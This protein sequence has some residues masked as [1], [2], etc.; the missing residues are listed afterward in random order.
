[1]NWSATI[2][3]AAIGTDGKP[4]VKFK[5][6]DD[7]GNPISGLAYPS[8]NTINSTAPI[9]AYAHLGF[10][11][12][13]LV[14]GTN[15]S[16]NRWVSYVV[17][18]TPS[19]KSATD[20]TTGTNAAAQRVPTT[21]NQGTMV[22]DAANPGN[23]TD[24]FVRSVKD[25][26]G[27]VDAG[28]YTGNNVKSF[29]D[30]TT[31]DPTLTHRVALQLQGSM[32]GTGTNMPDGI[33]VTAAVNSTNPVAAY[34]DFRPDGGAV[35]ETRTITRVEVCQSCHKGNLLHGRK[36]PNLCVTCHTQ[37]AGYGYA[38]VAL[39]A[40]D[41]PVGTGPNGTVAESATVIDGV[42]TV[43][44]PRWIHRIHMGE[45]LSKKNQNIRGVTPNEIAFPQDQRNCV[46]CHDSSATAKYPTPDG[47]HWKT[48][49]SRLACGGCHDGIN[50]ATGAG[51]TLAG[52]NVGHWGKAQADDSKCSLCHAP[53]D[54]DGYH[55]P[56]SP[57]A[58]SIKALPAGSVATGYTNAAAIAAYD[59]LPVGAIKVG[60]DI[61]SVTVNSSGN[62]AM[63]FRLLQNGTAVPFNTYSATG[64]TEIWDN[65][66]GAPGVEIAFNVPQDGITAP[67]DYNA[68]YD[69]PL[70]GIWNGKGTGT[71][72]GTLT[73]PDASGWYTVTLTG[74]KI[75]T[76]ATM[77]TMGLG[78]T[79][80]PQATALPLTQT[81]LVGYPYAAATMIGGLIVEVPNAWM[82]AS[83]KTSRRLL[84]E[85][86]RC[87]TCHAKLG[88]FAESAYHAG[89]RNNSQSCN[90]CHNPN[91]TSSGWSASA[92]YFVHA[93]HGATKRSVQNTWHFPDI[94]VW[95]IGN[96]GNIKNCS[97][98]HLPGAI[99]AGAVYTKTSTFDVNPL[100]SSIINSTSSA[101]A[102]TTFNNNF[103][104]RLYVTVGTGTF[105]VASTAGVLG[106][107]TVPTTP[108]SPYVA[109]NT[110]YGAG[111]AYAPTTG[112]STD[113]AA[114]TLV[115]SPVTNACFSCHDTTKAQQHMTGFGGSIYA[116][117]AAALAKVEQCQLCHAAGKVADVE[118]VHQ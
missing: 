94:D 61:S 73:G 104:N 96:P 18:S 34:L 41:F 87:N 74:I 100:S 48:V 17:N 40:G 29:L 107:S 81:N 77:V 63:K 98:C 106:S 20:H 38:S 46:K 15:G 31:F 5:V 97:A 22:E 32:P 47:D 19:F 68:H 21:D 42:S 59:K 115:N 43:T 10:T 89:Q 28:T 112:V 54:I 85:D 58:A 9:P 8:L 118:V 11:V 67:A 65:F 52:D 6:L 1:M 12:A 92:N 109:L 51:I 111:F 117:R 86:A 60:Y 72:A 91:Q 44:F 26:K 114:T 102:V 3:S 71:S 16:P 24:T 57:I 53:A 79:Y 55:V 45:G 78:Y 50:F 82:V 23:Y 88:V 75:P 116:P 99:N 76:T 103:D 35:T 101:S 93:I 37:Q 110:N 25:A 108:T 4:V 95:G 105:T 70:K 84:V 113:A 83:G 7:K 90:F 49:P 39:P 2:S 56:V 27:I 66:V 13:K 64:K 14:P 62:G 33:T 80:A 36:D 69:V 30:D